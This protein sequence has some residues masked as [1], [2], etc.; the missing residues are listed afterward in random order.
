MFAAEEEEEGSDWSV[1]K[2]IGVLA[3][4]TAGVVYVSETL[5]ATIEQLVA[6]AEVS[7][8]FIGAVV[9]AV[10]GAAAEIASAIRAA[11]KNR[12]DL[13]FAISMGGSVQIALFVA[14]MMVFLSYLVGDQP[15]QLQFDYETVLVLF[16]CVM[17]TMQLAR[18][19]RATWF[20]GAL[21]ILVYVILAGGIYLVS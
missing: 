21:L 15:L 18:D 10:I 4:V 5:S 12:M 11:R 13:A 14:P 20:K 16:F 19:G 17:I 2:A 3:A 6:E 9:V 1:L 8:L 7:G